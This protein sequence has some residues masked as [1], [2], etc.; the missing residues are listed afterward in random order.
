MIV[1]R[2]SKT[3]CNIKNNKSHHIGEKSFFGFIKN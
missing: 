3:G 1:E 2:M